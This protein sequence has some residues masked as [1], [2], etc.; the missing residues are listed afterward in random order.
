MPLDIFEAIWDKLND[1][2]IISS[3]FVNSNGDFFSLP[4]YM[5]YANYIETHSKVPVSITTNGLNLEYIP[6]V[7][8]FVISF[9]GCDKETYEYTTGNHFETV[10]MNIKNAYRKLDENPKKAELHCL[11]WEGNPDPEDKLWELFSDFP[12]KIR[13]SYKC[14]NAQFSGDKTLPEYKETTRKP[15]DYLEK[16]TVYPT[17]DVVPCC[18]DFEGNVQ[19]GNLIHD[20]VS[21]CFFSVDRAEKRLLH[22]LGK[23]CGICEE[24]NYNVD[25]RGKIV[26]LK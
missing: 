14:D 17:G 16:L 7:D 15:C 10:V 5:W 9:N 11:V 22:S 3:I 2:W 6:K 4:N 23:Y 12:G 21:K 8:T 1:S 18:H 24:C 19:W 20:S 25:L 13:L 26:Y